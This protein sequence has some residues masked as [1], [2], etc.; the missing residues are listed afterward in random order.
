MSIIAADFISV[1]ASVF[2]VCTLGVLESS[3]VYKFNLV[4]TAFVYCLDM[5][6]VFACS[7]IPVHTC[8]IM[9]GHL[10]VLLLSF[11]MIVT[12]HSLRRH[13]NWVMFCNNF[14]FHNL[15]YFALLADQWLPGSEGNQGPDGSWPHP[16]GL[17]AL[18]PADL[19]QG[20]QHLRIGEAVVPLF[21]LCRRSSSALGQLSSLSR[22]C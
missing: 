14:S 7:K 5:S 11:S 6:F 8:K 13:L 21:A 18:K 9:I 2:T 10:C 19:H 12:V 1:Y 4:V 17:S 15:N 20:N 3:Q 22:V 16:N